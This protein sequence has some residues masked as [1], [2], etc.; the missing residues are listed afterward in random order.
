MLVG[1]WKRENILQ[2]SEK[3]LKHLKIHS[4]YLLCSNSWHCSCE[5][6]WLLTYKTTEGSLQVDELTPAQSC[7]PLLEGR[8][9]GVGMGMSP[10]IL[11]LFL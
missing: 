3:T 7:D 2:L 4:A 1:K 8:K 11:N 10:K 9:K 5:Q 6:F